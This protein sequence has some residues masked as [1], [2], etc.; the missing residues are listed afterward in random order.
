MIIFK[1]W[2][3]F[4][5]V[6]LMVFSL[7][8]EPNMAS[9]E[10]DIQPFFKEY[11]NSCHG[12]KKQKGK[13]RLDTL[14]ID[15]KSYANTH[16][17][18][19]ILLRITD[20]DMPPED[21]TQPSAKKTDEIRDWIAEL[22]YEAE[23]QKQLGAGERVSFRRITREEYANTIKDL[24]GV[25]FDVT[26][27]HGLPKDPD[28]HGVERIGEVLTLS[29]TH[30]EKYYNAA[31][32]VLDE[33]LS[34]EAQP[35]RKVHKWDAYTMRSG[36]FK[37]EY[38]AR[39]IEDRARIDLVP[40]NYTS[41]TW[42]VPIPVSGEYQL[43]IKLSGVGPKDGP[44]PRLKVHMR[45]INRTLLEQEIDAPEDQPIVITKKVHLRRRLK[46]ETN[47]K[48]DVY[49]KNDMPGPNP[50][51]RRSRHTSI[52]N[53]FT[54]LKTR[55]PWQIK[56]TDDNYEPIK[57]TLMIDWIEWDGPIHDTWPSLA[58]QRI[59]FPGNKD[60]AHAKAILKRF[61]E[62]AWRRPVKEEEVNTL[63]QPVQFSLKA[64]ESFEY[65]VRSGLLAILCSNS[66]LY[67]EEGD[68][69]AYRGTLNNWELASR[70]S[71]FLWS[72]MPDDQLM[73]R[74]EEG[75]LHIP[76]VL[77]REVRRMLSD[78]KAH[79]F[80]D[81]FSRQWLQLEKVGMFVP[82]KDL[83]P[84]YNQKLENNMLS[85]TKEYF[86]EV[87][88]KNFSLSEFLDSDWTMLNER[89]AKHYGIDGVKGDEVRRVA[90]RPENQRG[91]IMTHA[92]ILGLT[93]DGTRHRP[94]HRGVW[95]LEAIIGKPAPPPPANV[96]ALETPKKDDKKR[97][98][99]E[100]LE[101][102]R[103]DPNCVSCHNKIDPLGIAFDNYD[104]IGRWREVETLDVGK[105]ENPKLD[106]SGVLPDGRKFKN[107][108]ELRQF[109]VKDLD[110]FAEAFTE[111]LAT[112]G[113]RRGMT[114]SDKQL[115]KEC[116]D[117]AKSDHYQIHSVIE[118]L[119]TSPLFVKR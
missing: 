74:V 113:M 3:C 87:F 70:L 91:G 23:K 51:G 92:S 31:S 95:M 4:L 28:W 110:Q 116:V 30:I 33:A 85:E 15:F 75:D 37:D 86:R 67:L 26:G 8:A 16:V 6:S 79:A 103:K 59:F 88:L 53:A 65:S 24:L 12:E 38:R 45:D 108:K 34:L 94:V 49:I 68:V 62:R 107:S 89:L 19:E 118:A 22:L 46:H 84:T 93:S 72:T 102:H 48:Y 63:F 44:K 98:L 109:L 2:A 50:E 56:L 115:I 76:E 29:P 9:L 41:D 25:T 54:D 35:E 61:A 13:L 47:G 101:L 78:K 117:K 106:S 7:E 66:F 83:Y 57:P 5:L 69:Q 82:D 10:K 58:H 105:G 17:W 64:K 39:G 21:E 40:N 100:T 27:A 52:A 80:V 1:K 18:E 36:H 81:S 104:A 119:V 96:P 112:Y 99:R 114:Y 97:T 90:L 11:C 14:G 60:E 42:A 73:T 71:Y 111:K 43:R 55:V 32:E 20:Q 77:S